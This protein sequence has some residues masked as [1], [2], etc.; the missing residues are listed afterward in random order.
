MALFQPGAQTAP[1]NR[2]RIA[3]L[4]FAL[5]VFSLAGYLLRGYFTDDTIIHLR[6]VENL[7]ERSEFSFNPGERTYGASSPLWIFGLALLVKLGLNPLTAAWV[8]GGLS[9]LA[10]ILAADAIIERLTFAPRWKFVLMMLVV[11]DVWFL[12]WSFSGMETPLA[13]ALL[14]LLLR[15]L[16]LARPAGPLWHRY[17]AWGV[18]AGLAGLVRPEFM[19]MVPLA[20]PFLLW[21]EYFRAGGMEGKP[22]RHR[23]RPHAPILAAVSGWLLVVGPWLV[24]A[25]SSFGR[26]FPETAAAKSVGFSLMP[27]V[28]FPYL[29]RSVGMLAVTQG[30]LWV[31]VILLIILILRRHQGLENSRGYLAPEDSSETGGKTSTRGV[32]PWSVWGP[33]AIVGIAVTWAAVLLGGLAL[34]QVWVVS[35]YVSPLGPVLL[36]AISVVVEWLMQGAAVTVSIRKTGRVIILVAVLGTLIFNGWMFAAKVLPH[37]RDFPAGLRDCYFELAHW[38]RDNTPEDAMV[39]AL[40]IG[41]IGYGSDRT[42]LDLMGLVSPEILEL[43]QEMGFEELV[44]SGDW[45][46]AGSRAPDY[47]VDRSEG[48]PR[49]AGRT[50]RGI[51]FELLDTCVIKGLGLN[52]SQPWTV[53]LYRL[54]P[55]ET[56]VKSSAGG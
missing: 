21:F 36:L 8:L 54:V 5:L 53:A 27:Q 1:M 11:G 9:G 32:G 25:W 34:R 35:R 19:L 2:N 28:W 24:F 47:L 12:R 13:T 44:V 56:G 37:A 40:D 23:A 52:E 46:A 7:L 4:L 20:L 45:L 22:G 39:A 50:V 17:L 6:Y 15:P 41:A 49:W 3:R 14:V 29:F 48:A 26:L 10:L 31:G 38:L 51:R 16:I 30:L 42:V 18:G 55:V 43:G 33:V